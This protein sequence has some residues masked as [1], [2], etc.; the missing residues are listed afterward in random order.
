MTNNT[1]KYLILT[2]L[3]DEPILEM[4]RDFLQN[5]SMATHYV[6]PDF[7]VDP[8]AGDD[9]DLIKF[10]SWAQIDGLDTLGYEHETRSGSD[11]VD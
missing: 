1:D 5:A 11:Q 10:Y 9:A 3:P 6:T 2:D 7:F 8:F 4:W